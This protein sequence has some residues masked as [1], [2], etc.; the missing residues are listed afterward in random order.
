MSPP[1]SAKAKL[2]AAA[3]QYTSATL[4]AESRNEIYKILIHEGY[5]E[6]IQ[7]RLLHRLHS[8]PSNWP[9][10]LEQRGI[11]MLR[12][13]E[14]DTFPKL[15]K[16]ILEEVRHD[17][18]AKNSKDAKNGEVN[19]ATTNG[20]SK[21][22]NGAGPAENGLALPTDVVQDLVRY[23]KEL[24]KEVMETDDSDDGT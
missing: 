17:T 15:I 2:P 5:V 18:Q 20:K 4:D 21:A 9:T 14:A 13:G 8:D 6:K 1:P 12:N 24:L 16:K 10:T 19:G 3:D 11:D 7:E 22:V 23:T